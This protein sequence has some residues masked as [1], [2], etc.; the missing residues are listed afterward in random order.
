MPSVTRLQRRCFS[1][2][3]PKAP[4]GFEG[5]RRAGAPCRAPR[6][7]TT[8]AWC[9]VGR[10]ARRTRAAYDSTQACTDDV[11]VKEQIPRHLGAA[12]AFLEKLLEVANGLLARSFPSEFEAHRRTA[13]HVCR[14]AQHSPT[15]ES[16]NMKRLR[17]TAPAAW[18]PR[19]WRS[20]PEPFGLSPANSLGCEPAQRIQQH[21]ERQSLRHRCIARGAKRLVL[22]PQP[23]TSSGPLTATQGCT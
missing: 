13:R 4:R 9:A 5:H 15:C 8:L 10:P 20:A 12:V 7:S 16:S 23:G 21:E 19:R 3:S 18:R 6:R 22:R 14:R 17:S 2:R 11:L 1:S